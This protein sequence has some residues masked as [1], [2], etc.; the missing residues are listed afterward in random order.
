MAVLDETDGGRLPLKFSD[1]DLQHLK[2]AQGWIELGA[3]DVANDDCHDAML[4]SAAYDRRKMAGSGR[5]SS[6]LGSIHLN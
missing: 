3:W 5:W 6:V 2:E 4:N 1:S